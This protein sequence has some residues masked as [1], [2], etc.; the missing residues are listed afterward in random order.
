M[1]RTTALTAALLTVAFGQ[2]LG[3][4]EE[5]HHS[6]HDTPTA[7]ATLKAPDG[8][9][10]GTV[11]LEETPFSGVIVT[12]QAEGLEQG[13]HGFHIHET[14]SCEAPDFTSAGGHFA[15]RGNDHGFRTPGGSHAGDLLNLQVPADGRI[16]SSRLAGGATLLKDAPHSL[17]DDDGSAIVIH[18][19][20]DDY[21]SQPSGAAGPRVACGVIQR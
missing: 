8:R 15:P 4:Q 13:P 16:I 10:V 21:E 2:G 19:G 5:E 1:I 11:R 20:A 18:G 9:T 7:T 3:A 6:A 14:G 17:F 12:L